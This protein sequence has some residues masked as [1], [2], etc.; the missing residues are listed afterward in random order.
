MRTD[1]IFLL[2]KVTIRTNYPNIHDAIQ[3]LQ[4][5]TDYHIGNTENVEVLETEIIELKTKE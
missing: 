5:G 4:R 3:E 1:K 2:V